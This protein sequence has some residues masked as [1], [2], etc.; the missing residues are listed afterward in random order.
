MAL[1]RNLAAVNAVLKHQ[2]E[3]AT[4]EFLAAIRGAVRPH[5]SLA[6]Y[7]CAY[8]LVLERVNRLEREIAPVNVDDRAGFVV[9][10]DQPAVLD[11]VTQRRH[12]THPHA[13]FLR[14]RNLVADSFTGDLPLELGE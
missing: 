4:G 11:V 13:L 9:V 7:P 14:R 12:A 8:E 6:P 3:C 5:P 1:M 10:D 2:I